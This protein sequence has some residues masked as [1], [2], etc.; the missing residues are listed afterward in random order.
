MASLKA[1]L[2]VLAALI[3][4]I[5]ILPSAAFAAANN[6]ILVPDFGYNPTNVSMYLYVPSKLAPDPPIFVNPHWCHGTAQDA[7]AGTQFATLADTYGY[8]MI[9]PSSPHTVDN[10]WDVSSQ[11]TLTHNGG[12]DSLAIVN[13]VRYVLETYKADANRVF[14]MGT[15]S[16]AMMTNVLLGAYPDV[17]AAGSAWA[18]VAF[19]CFAA[20]SSAVDL[21]SGDCATGTVIKTGTQ[22]KSIVQAAYPGYTGFRPK[23][24]VLHG[25]VDTTLYPQNL[26]EEIKEWTAV[27]GQSSTPVSTLQDWPKPNWTTW[28]YGSKFRAT[29]AKGVDHNIPTNES[30]VLDW[31][32]LRCQGTGCYSKVNAGGE[33]R[34][35][36]VRREGEDSTFIKRETEIEER[37]EEERAVVPLYGQCGGPGY[38]GATQCEEG[39]FCTP[40]GPVN[41]VVPLDVFTDHEDYPIPGSTH[42]N[43]PKIGDLVYYRQLVYNRFDAYQVSE[44][45]ITGTKPIGKQAALGYNMSAINPN[46]PSTFQPKSAS[47][48]CVAANGIYFGLRVQCTTRITAYSGDDDD[49]HPITAD[50]KYAGFGNL[51]N[52]DFPAEWKLVTCL[53]F[54]ITEFNT[55]VPVSGSDRRQDF[56][57]GHH[58]VRFLFNDFSARYQCER[59]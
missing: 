10:C 5:S 1:S 13:M 24:W 40:S 16:G 2:R 23:M 18:G 46:V 39:T 36:L 44:V 4:S 48:G 57:L 56:S 55:S 37:G 14:S 49:G 51:T 3:T 43:L 50:C 19:G 38:S 28:S 41:A 45:P 7:F 25:S 42:S 29:S 9:F 30:V 47:L 58:E 20:N 52:C 11:Q 53:R 17:F 31:F 12:S 32:D 34:G 54:E 33:R 6:L 35:K 22:W 59:N 21:W 27:L 26:Q 8:I 15:S